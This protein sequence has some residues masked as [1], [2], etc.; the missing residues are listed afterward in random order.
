MCKMK[1]HISQSTLNTFKEINVVIYSNNKIAILKPY[2][3]ESIKNCTKDLLKTFI[4]LFEG[5]VSIIVF[6][7][8]FLYQLYCFLPIVRFVKEDEKQEIE[9]IK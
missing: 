4:P 3:G 9:S 5:L 8:K 7:F 1:L 6:P 2:T